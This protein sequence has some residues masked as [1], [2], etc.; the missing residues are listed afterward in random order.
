MTNSLVGT[1]TN[2]LNPKLA[3]LAN[4]GGPTETMALESGSPAI[5][6]GVSQVVYDAFVHNV[7]ATDQRGIGRP[8]STGVDMGAYQTGT[9]R[10]NTVTDPTG[11]I[12][13]LCSLRD[14]ITVADQIG[15]PQTIL[16][17]S[18]VTGTI[19]LA[20]QL[21]AISSEV[22]LGGGTGLMPITVNGGGFG[23]V[24]TINAGVTAQI[25]DLNITGGANAMYGG[26]IFSKGT[27]TLINSTLSGNSAAD[28]GGIY[29]GGMTTLAN[30]TITGNTAVGVAGG[31][32]AGDGIVAISDCTISGNTASSGAGLFVYNDITNCTINGTII[33]GNTGGDI[34]KQVS[35]TF[36]GSTDLIGDGSDGGVLTNT[37]RGTVGSPLNPDLGPLADYG[38]PTETLELFSGSPAVGHGNNF[39]V[40]DLNGNDVT[41]FDQ[42]GFPRSAGQG[43]DIGAIQ[44]GPLRVNVLTDPG[45]ETV[46]QL[47][48]REAIVVA[49][50]FGVQLPIGFVGGLTG[51][52]NLSGSLPLLTSSTSVNGPGESVIAVSGGGLGTVFSVGPGVTALIS[53]LTIED[54][55]SFGLFD[56]N[57]GEA[58]GIDNLGNLT[59]ANCIITGNTGAFGGGVFSMG[60]LT[61]S[62]TTI[63]NNA[64]MEYI[65]SGIGIGGVGGGIDDTGGMLTITGSTISGNTSQT[66]G[67][68][69]LASDGPAL[70]VSTTTVSGN[71]AGVGFNG[72]GIYDI[73]MPLTISNSTIS[74]NSGATNGG[75]VY[76]IQA[77]PTIVNSTINGNSAT[78]GGGVFCNSTA[79][80]I[81]D[82][83]VAGNSGGGLTAAASPVDLT[84]E[85][86]IVASN[87]G[88]DLSRDSGLFAFAGSNDLIG[89]GSDGGVLANSLRGS[90]G[91]PLNPM[92]GALAANGGVTD[93]MALLG[94][95]PAISAGA[96]FTVTDAGGNDI[97]ATDQRG[98]P[99]PQNGLFD[100]GAYEVQ[101]TGFVVTTL[102]DP[103]TQA[104]GVLSLREAINDVESFG[105]N[106]IITFL[107]GLNGAI[108][109]STAFPDIT[110]NITIDGPGVRQVAIGVQSAGQILTVD[111]GGVLELENL[112]INSGAVTVNGGGQ[113]ELALHAGGF[114]LSAL[115]IQTGGTMDITNNSVGIDY[116]VGNSSPK[117]AVANDISAGAI[118]SSTARANS[119]DAVGYADGSSDAGTAAA[120]GQVLVRYTL[121]GDANLDRLV[122]FQDLVA[123]VQNFNKNGTDWS[124]GNFSFGS[125]TN[126]ND[127]VTVVQNFNKILTPAGSSSAGGEGVTTE[128]LVQPAAENSKKANGGVV[129]SDN[130]LASTAAGQSSDVNDSDPAL[131][132]TDGAAGS[133]LTD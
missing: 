16:F 109:V 64:A 114:T 5:G 6:S 14:A 69:V 72:A 124:T 57:T 61:V 77:A 22:I 130:Y 18:D 30:C 110:G 53:G 43:H 36:S 37:Q 118:F 34:A 59:L 103:A 47:S 7:T 92:L 129:S 20:S 26:G 68:G 54:G 87:T 9:I 8:L 21:P 45:T 121:N 51:T 117:S 78:N 49:N 70:I 65:S 86:A 13:G 102:A 24:F 17:D 50:S 84:L 32:N 108:T 76:A 90:A 127:L 88:G 12:P 42:R 60:N 99:R 56:F 71:K 82:C 122:N 104:A 115:T 105:G 106:Q 62:N 58:G 100:M 23:S 113:L 81:V 89:D 33:A 48:L 98:L 1:K 35:G 15:T 46:G 3:P 125:S 63:S 91:S 96:N 31:V 119:Q 116:G 126:F 73:D 29:G 40:T 52:I 107:A 55:N 41:I 19:N 85:G 67:G 38:G 27:L 66:N 44:S 123:V 10:I 11:F 4:N 111:S 133:I 83:T 120:P 101:R 2:P 80:T 95:S 131:L 112:S 28:G 25:D 94:G 93:T 39:P 128:P 132:G 97:T 79:L 75:G 74:G